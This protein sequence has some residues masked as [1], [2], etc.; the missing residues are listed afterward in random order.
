MSDDL[1]NRGGRDRSS[2]DV[3]EEWEVRNRADKFGMTHEETAK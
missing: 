2:V 3:N 1:Q